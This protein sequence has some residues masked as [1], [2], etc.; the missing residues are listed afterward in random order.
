MNTERRTFR[1]FDVPEAV[2]RFFDNARLVIGADPDE[3]VEPDSRRQVDAAELKSGAFG[4]QITPDE[5]SFAELAT[6]TRDAATIYGEDGVRLVVVVGSSYLKIVDVVVE[7]PLDALERVVQVT[8]GTPARA[9]RA[10]HHGCDIEAFLL[11]GHVLEEQPLQAWRKG[12]WLSRARFEL[13]TGLDGV[14]FNVLPLTD[15]E[16]ARIGL[17]SKTLRYVALEDSPLQVS[18][19]STVNLYVDSELLA[20]LKREPRKNWAKAFTDQLATDVLSAIALRALADPD[21]REA[22]WTGVSE[23]LLGG[24]IEMIDGRPTGDE[25]ETTNNRQRLLEELRER[26]HRFLALIEGA[27]E[28]RDSA[29]LIVGS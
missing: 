16:R 3:F 20:R 15:D 26:P 25:A 13:R 10:V 21:V 2:E 27:C 29:K 22:D 28:M 12:T 14:G 11:L 19:T 6:A 23:T 17:P 7:M 9:F 5:S 8:N 18:A 1:P 4:L 24:L